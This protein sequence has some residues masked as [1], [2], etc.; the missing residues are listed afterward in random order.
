MLR[1]EMPAS[2]EQTAALLGRVPVFEELAE[3][4]LRRVAEVKA[5]V[6]VAL[7]AMAAAGA[8]LVDVSIPHADIARHP[9]VSSVLSQG[10][11]R[12]ERGH[13]LLALFD[14]PRLRRILARLQQLSGELAGA[15]APLAALKARISTLRREIEAALQSGK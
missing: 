8:T 12:G 2:A 7:D 9:S 4:D 6:E 15:Q 10:R 13:Q 3:E 1:A 14:E 11:F 5:A